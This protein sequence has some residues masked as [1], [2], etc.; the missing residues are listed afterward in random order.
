MQKTAA[1]P[2]SPRVGHA[3]EVLRTPAVAAASGS[4][5]SG[6]ASTPAAATI[7]LT[8]GY[9]GWPRSSSMWDGERSRYKHT[10]DMLNLVN[11]ST[12]TQ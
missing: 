12:V 3:V 11:L 7:Y 8:G 9:A 6:S 10:T 4:G 2:W 5:S 1:A